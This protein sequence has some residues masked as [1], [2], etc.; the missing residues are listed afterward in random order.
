MATSVFTKEK[1]AQIKG[2][3]ED[4]LR[5]YNGPQDKEDDNVDEEL[6]KIA[7]APPINFAE[8]NAGFERQAKEITSSMLKFYS[9][10]GVLDKYEYIKEKQKL[11]NTSISNI[12][13]QLK[14]IRMAIER[15]AEEINQGN[16]HPRLFEVFGQLQDKLTA[17]VKTQANY[18]LFL[19]DTYKKIKGEIDQN[20]TETNPQLPNSPRSGE[21]YIGA[22]TKNMMKEI[23]VEEIDMETDGRHLTHPSKKAEVMI[24]KGVDG[25]I[26]AEE[27][28]YDFTD[29][30]NSLI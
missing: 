16:T 13:F 28:V 11:D 19:E 6:A 2:E 23:E 27:D 14:T 20:N 18:M 9:D 1:K 22:G 15:I 12:F 5:S 24:E 29:D 7:A 17:V 3:L 26:L 30:V 10:L 25:T 4:L 21:Y 8:L